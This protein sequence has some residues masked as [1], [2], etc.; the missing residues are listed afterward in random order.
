MHVCVCMYVY[1]LPSPHTLPYSEYLF[2][3]PHVKMQ[4]A[5]LVTAAC[6]LGVGSALT[7][8]CP[9]WNPANYTVHLP[10]Q[11]DCGLFYSCSWG[12]PVLMHCPAGL[13]FNPALQVCDWPWRAAC[14]GDCPKLPDLEGGSWS[15]ASCIGK[16]S[17][18]GDSCSLKCTA[19]YE[20]IGSASVS[21][22][23]GSWSG[24]AGVGHVPS[25]KT[26]EDFGAEF[27][28]KINRTL[29]GVNASLLFVLDESGS[30]SLS[31][32]DMEKT[33]VKAIVNAF[34]LSGSRSA[35]V[36]TFSDT[37]AV[38]VRADQ[39]STCD[40]LAAVEGIRYTG[41]GTDI[42]LAL[43]TAGTELRARRAH[44]RVLVFLLT[45][46]VSST[47]PAAA[48]D[49]LKGDNGTVFAIGVGGYV[50]EQLEPLSSSY[51]DGSRLFFGVSSFAVFDVVAKYLEA[52]YNNSTSQ[53]ATI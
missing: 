23:D 31:Q 39:N 43:E 9:L 48:A 47:D 17:T 49:A 2:P 11:A 18:Q 24:S 32:F 19:G 26:P 50:R 10:H 51:V 1:I 12:R 28:D 37:A 36:V 21:C 7:P 16:L 4:G 13:H 53:C 25:C 40:F 46:G 15:P 42:K 5:L 33:F 44:S 38:D 27:V 30:V 35:G 6:L 41:G 29:N 22:I 45:D 14:Q 20:L 3:V 8:A 52:A 34:P